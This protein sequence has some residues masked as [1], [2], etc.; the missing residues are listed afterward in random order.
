[1]SAIWQAKNKLYQLT[2][3]LIDPLKRW[4]L[5]QPEPEG[6]LDLLFKTRAAID[7]LITAIENRQGKK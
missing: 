6:I 1:M 7:E 5:S 3:R 2:E 4:D